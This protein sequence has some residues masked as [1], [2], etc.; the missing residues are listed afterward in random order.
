MSGNTEGRDTDESVTIYTI[1]VGDTAA[2]VTFVTY[3]REMLREIWRER[4]ADRLAS[5]ARYWRHRRI[6][7]WLR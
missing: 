4:H 3:T 7:G 5:G 1:P 6:P 2:A